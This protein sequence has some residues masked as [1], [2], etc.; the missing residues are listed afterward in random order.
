MSN[1]MPRNYVTWM[2]DEWDGDLGGFRYQPERDAYYLGTSD[3]PFWRVVRRRKPYAIQRSRL[4]HDAA[5][6]T[7][8]RNPH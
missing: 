2:R 4:K 6:A 1:K 8:Q 3:G 7:A 5:P